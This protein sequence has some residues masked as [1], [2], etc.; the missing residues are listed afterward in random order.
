[1]NALSPFQ[2]RL[3][4]VAAAMMSPAGSRG[5]LLTLIFHRVP[6]HIDPMNSDEPDAAEFAARMDLL[7]DLFQVM[8]LR[9]AA[10]RLARGSLPERAACVTFDDGYENN[11]SVAA[12]ILAAR[13]MTATFF[14]ATGFLGSGCMW[15][16]V[17]IEAL[18]RCGD[19]INLT[20]LG[21]GRYTLTDNSERSRVA[22]K[23]L[24][25]LKYLPPSE[26]ADRARAISETA[27]GVAPTDLMMSEEQVRQ[28]IALGMEVGAHSVSH[29]ILTRVDDKTARREIEESKHRLEAIT[30]ER[31]TSFAYPNGRP[32]QDYDRA[33]IEMVR[34]AGFTAAVST[35]WGCARTGADLW[36]LPRISPWD[37]T[38]L[39]YGLRLLRTYTQPGAQLV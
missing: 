22:G 2:K 14:V 30:G 7:R 39:R 27:G 11:C 33:H 24:A 31:V 34:T 28:L 18:R 20:S 16:D 36:Q 15:N 21:L 29:P 4:G 5:A 17:V 26:R 10:Q 8:P 38:A 32:R 9:E 1:M 23:L 13:G 37:N 19:S 12:P 25:K 3:L 6:A 35:A